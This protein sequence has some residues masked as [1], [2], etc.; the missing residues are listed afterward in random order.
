MFEWLKKLFSKKEEKKTKS[1]IKRVAKEKK[2]PCKDIKLVK[3]K[4]MTKRQRQARDDFDK[5]DIDSYT[6]T[7][8]DELKKT[9]DEIEDE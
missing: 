1:P 8:V 9:M 6:I 4:E 2:I 7:S 3:E 5:E